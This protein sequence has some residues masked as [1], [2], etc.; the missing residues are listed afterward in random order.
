MNIHNIPEISVVIP[1]YKLDNK[2]IPLIDSLKQQS[3]KPKEI[4]IVF[5]EYEEDI[6]NF[7]SREKR[8]KLLRLKDDKGPNH[9]RNIG[10]KNSESEYIAFIDSDCIASKTWIEEI[11]KNFYLYK[12]DAIAGSVNTLNKNVFLARFQEY[13]LIKPIPKFS[14]VKILRK[15]LWLNLIVTANFIVK[16]SIALKIGG[17]DE[18]FYRFGADDLDFA[19]RLL[20]NGYKILCSPN[21]VVYHKNR[22]KI[23][24]IIRRYFNYGEGFSLYRVRHPLTFF[25]L[26]ITLSAYGTI[27][28][29]TLATYFITRGYIRIPSLVFITPM[30][31]T[32][33][34]HSLYS[35][36]KKDLR[37]ERIIYPFIDYILSLSSIIGIF[38]MDLSLL[39]KYIRKIFHR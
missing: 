13:S 8:I 19:T 17:F 22:E 37:L 5:S 38:Y 35:F 11:I 26:I 25:S 15:H 32:T 7:L 34:Y 3:I 29:Y 39:F 30:L 14:K 31:I 1:V 27:V 28:G 33:L 16:K 20:H 2:I 10:L 24:K 21:V 18:D 4:L 36:L 9:A 6:Y 12:T 23:G